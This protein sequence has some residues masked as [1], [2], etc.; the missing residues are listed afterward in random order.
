MNRNTTEQIIIKNI[1]GYYPAVQGIYLFGSHGQEDERPDSDVDVALLLPY[2][3][4]AGHPNLVLSP[5]RIKLARLLG[6]EVDL[7][8]ARQV[9]TVFQKE[10]ITDGRLILCADKYAV[11]EFEML[12]ISFYQKLNEERADILKAFKATGRAYAI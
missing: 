5:C 9:S 6:K 1:L 11:D 8:N 4:M 3:S 10:I 7:V 12:V 2:D